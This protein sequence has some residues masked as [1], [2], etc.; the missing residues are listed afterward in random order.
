VCSSS[1]DERDRLARHA[2][3][4]HVPANLHRFLHEETVQI[5]T[6]RFAGDSR[7]PKTLQPLFF[8]RKLFVS[9]KNTF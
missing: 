6:T 8:L 1:G 3:A 9:N 7:A 4:Q 2:A 5:N